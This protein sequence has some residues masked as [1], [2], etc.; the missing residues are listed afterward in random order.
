[1]GETPML[2]R[3]SMMRS[4]YAWV[5]T[6]VLIFGGCE[7]HEPTAMTTTRPSPATKIKLA[8]NWKPEPE[9]GGFYAAQLN[10][11]YQSNNLDV[12]IIGGG[13]QVAQMVA[14]GQV[15]FG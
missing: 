12:A 9:F 2:R 1:M 7:K 5:A 8:L 13:D 14:A 15:D 10:G 11:A 4:M 6:M 3:R